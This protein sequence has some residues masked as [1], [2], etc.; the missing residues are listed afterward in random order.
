LIIRQEQIDALEEVR[1]PD[2]ENAM[3]G[4]LKDFAPMHWESLGEEGIRNLIQIGVKRAATHGFTRRGP[5]RFYIETIILLG[6]GFDTDPQYRAIGSILADSVD[7]QT[8]RADKVYDWLMNYLDVVGGHNREHAHRALVHAYQNTPKP[9]RVGA[10]EFDEKVL[11]QMQE[12]HPEKVQY[13]GKDVL[14]A[15][16][17]RSLEEARKFAVDTDLGVCL[18]IALMF[19]IG[20]CFFEDPKY[21]WTLQTLTNPAIS[22]RDKR[23]E[24]LY[25]KTMT[26]LGYALQHG[27]RP[28]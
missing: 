5:V 26:Y 24:R 14:R 2:F 8:V 7:D 22:D 23:A 27:H 9:V 12:M 1:L 18:F 13:L 15:L 16:I 21:P 25:S 17:P 4:H 20:H 6:I 10:P 19:A 3:V 11:Q 28:A